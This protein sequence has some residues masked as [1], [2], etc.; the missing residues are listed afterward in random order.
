MNALNYDLPATA[1]S[2]D[3]VCREIDQWLAARRLDSERFPTA[4]LLRESLNNTVVHGGRN[5]PNRRMR[6]SVRCGRKWLQIVVEDDGPGFD[7]RS[8][9]GVPGRNRRVPGPRAADLST[10]FRRPQVQPARQPRAPAAS[11]PGRGHTCRPCWFRKVMP[12]SAWT[13]P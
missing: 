5:E 9:S 1:A 13:G 3:R 10:L 4:M 6:C 2:V 12:P 8:R 11:D 7:W